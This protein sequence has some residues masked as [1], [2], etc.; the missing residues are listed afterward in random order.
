MTI[1]RLLIICIAFNLFACSSTTSFTLL[2]LND[3]YELT[4]LNAGKTGGLA[5]VATL[6]KQLKA[7][8]P[9]TYSI[10]AGD[11]LS[12]SALGTAKMNDEALAGKQIIDVF[13]YLHWDYAT[14]GNH[15]F[16]IG[17][18]ALLDRLAET[19]T[20]F[21]SSNVLDAET[22][23]LFPHT[24]ETV[25]L[26]VDGIK[27]G[28]I[29][30]TLPELS[31]AFVNISD[32][33]QAAQQ[34]IAKL[35]PQV[36]MII[37][38]THQN[39]DDDIKFAEK[40]QGIDLIIGG[41]EHENML[42]FRGEH[43][44]PITKADANAKSAFIHR[45]SI[46][47]TTGE[48]TIKSELVFLNET[49]PLDKEADVLIQQWQQKGFD[50]FR[51]QGFEPEHIVAHTH[52][53]LDGLEASVRNKTTA[54]T[55]LIANAFLTALPDA[56]VS[57]YNAG[58]IRIDDI[59]PA[60]DISEYDIIKI[61][62]FGNK[63]VLVEMSGELLEKA[64]NANKENKGKGSFLHYAN[65]QNNNGQWYLKNQGLDKNKRYK[66]A[67]SDYLVEKGDKGLD[68]LTFK[69]SPSIKKLSNQTIDQRKA[70]IQELS[71]GG[72]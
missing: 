13:N 67:I 45:I 71:K 27:I 10:L 15:E 52:Q 38:V 70:L 20:L 36:D 19:K 37:L 60:G 55:N 25:I 54:L 12:P 49:L 33:L 46:D 11:L 69:H 2:Q 39:Y 8:N 34:A 72:Y 3:V 44:T 48:K 26:N 5:R 66:V 21:F 28:L 24:K 18:K 41:H 64:L 17:K 1:Y 50:L 61:M 63:L 65:I 57:L 58:S 4:P 47:K 30:I 68:F 53:A 51:Q 22:H 29:G 56:D 6:Q 14:F 35:K 62:P 9:N 32:P 31:P 7:E 23:K 59:L 43:N 40:L 16:D 42:L